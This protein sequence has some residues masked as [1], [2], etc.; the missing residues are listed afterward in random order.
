MDVLTAQCNRGGYARM[1]VQTGIQLGPK[2]VVK[3]LSEGGRMID[4]EVKYEWL[5]V[6]CSVCKEHG[7]LT[8]YCRRNVTKKMWVVK[9]KPVPQPSEAANVEI[10]TSTEPVKEGGEWITVK[11]RRKP[12]IR[13]ES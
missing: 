6:R 8:A 4:Q 9:S 3:Y 12:S 2:K 11:S 7:H 13:A 5:P 10:D 1:M